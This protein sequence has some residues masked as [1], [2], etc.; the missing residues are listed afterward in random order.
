[1]ADLKLHGFWYSPF[2][3]R[4]LWTLK[5]KGI[6]YEY[7]DEDRFNKS[8]QLLEYNPVHKKVPVFVHDG[9]PICES[10][11]I[12]EYIN[13]LWP[14]NS[15]V[16]ADPYEK[17]VARFWVAYIDDMFSAVVRPLYRS[18]GSEERGEIIK[19][20][21]GRFRVIEDQCLGDHKKFLGGDTF[22]IVDIAFGSFVK[23]LVAVGDVVEVEIL[24]AE[25]FPRLH[26]WFNNFMDVPA[27]RD[28]TPDHEKLV[29]CLKSLKEQKEQILASSR[30]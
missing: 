18:N 19:D 21:W 14:Q 1:M 22:N 10:M 3:F 29:A 2:T 12:I 7:K 6:P 17:A 25:R 15:L 4:V 30:K 16:P 8:P 9:K 11:I 26:M 23:F 5:L 20:M 28:N 27:I 24:E 13:E